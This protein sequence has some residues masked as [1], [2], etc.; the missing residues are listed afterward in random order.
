[1]FSSEE[2]GQL[3]LHDKDRRAVPQNK[4]SIIRINKKCSKMPSFD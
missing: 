4:L 2:L 3:G 1:M